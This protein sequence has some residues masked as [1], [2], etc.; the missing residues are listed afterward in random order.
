VTQYFG[1]FALAVGMLAAIASVTL[2]AR[3][4]TRGGT[5]T[6]ARNGAWLVL[7]GAA[8]A[9]A[10]LEW[11][12]LTHDFSVRF[13]AENASR[14]T[15]LY[16]TITGMWAGADG[17]L[18]LWLLVLAVYLAV[19]AL[20]RPAG[21]A[22]LHA[23]AMVVQNL[24][25][26]FFFGLVLFTG[27]AFDPVSPVPADGPGPN[28][29]LQDHPA[30]GIHPPLLYAGLIGLGV[31]F[32]FA[33]AALVTGDVGRRWLDAVRTYTLVAWTALTAG[34]VLGAWWSYAVLGWG[35]YWAW[36]PV[37]NASLVPWLVA[38]ALLHSTMVQRQRG[39]LATWNLALAVTAFLLACLGTFLTRSSVVVSVHAFSESALGP[40]LL[41]FVTALAVGVGALVWLRSGS[42]GR[43]ASIGPAVSRGSTLLVNNVLLCC[44][45][46]TV[47]LGTL[48]PLLIQALQ[49]REV[50]V[51]PPYYNRIAVPIGLLLLLFMAVGPVFRWQGGDHSAVVRRLS[52]CVVFASVTVTTI[53]LA[54]VRGTAPLLA[55]GLAALVAASVVLDFSAAL[56]HFRAT[57]GTRWAAAATATL[58]HRRGRSAG[59]LAHLGVAIAV[60]GI[61]ASSAYTVT[62]EQEL[63]PGERLEISGVSAQLVGVGRHR[64]A[65]AMTTSARVTI[66]DADGSSRVRPGLSF[67]P[68]HGMT[69]AQPVVLGGVDQ[70]VYLTLLAVDRSRGSATLRLAVSP[71]VGWI[72]AGGA[73]AVLA[74][75]I[76]LWPRHRSRSPAVKPPASSL[77]PEQPVEA[78]SR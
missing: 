22:V 44:L 19:V 11:A 29:L 10:A 46:V 64:R 40:L 60:A 58:R 37:E 20:R 48:F 68:A 18:L 7:A 23:W 78:V 49:S 56:G 77:E 24:V 28:P 73:M 12:L 26:A 61:T 30:M 70:D 15:P 57:R 38:T 8:G 76:A 6:L 27:H 34:I 59:M 66:S 41:G 47:L 75:G 54:G 36:D 45:A 5:L 14:S 65:D 71:L 52:W 74:G 51:G 69:V 63:R 67:Y 4:A 1:T 43:P 31:P 2:W 33:V 50:T 62:A 32:A 42:L 16:Y 25:A 21:N 39:A 13:V 3:E 17:S 9:V 55:F 72:W 53:A 35:G